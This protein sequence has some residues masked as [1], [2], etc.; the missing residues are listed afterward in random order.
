VCENNT[1]EVINRSSNND[2][3]LYDKEQF[4]SDTALVKSVK[5]IPQVLFSGLD[6][7]G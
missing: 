7:G 3:N 4:N 2:A 5:N 1:Y 6:T